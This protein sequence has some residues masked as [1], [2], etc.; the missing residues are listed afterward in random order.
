MCGVLADSRLVPAM[1]AD[2]GRLVV[3]VLVLGP[4]VVFV[5][6]FW[7][8]AVWFGWTFGVWR[9]LCSRFRR[10]FGRR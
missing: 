7:L 1:I 3:G 10:R 9:P 4:G 2:V 6:A 8:V 5:A